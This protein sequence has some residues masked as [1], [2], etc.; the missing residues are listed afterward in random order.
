MNDIY[1]DDATEKEFLQVYA[2]ID[3]I[4]KE[5]ARLHGKIGNLKA[6]LKTMFAHWCET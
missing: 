4:K 1:N 2:Q 5:I 3:D 6:V